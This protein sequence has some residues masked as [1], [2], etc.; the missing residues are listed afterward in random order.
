MILL[1]EMPLGNIQIAYIYLLFGLQILDIDEA[2][3]YVFQYENQFFI[4]KIKINFWQL[5][6]HYDTLQLFQ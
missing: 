6:F 2:S 3:Y 4:F 1:F 5:S